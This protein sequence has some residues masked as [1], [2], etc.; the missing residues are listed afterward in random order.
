MVIHT[1]FNACNVHDVRDASDVLVIFSIGATSDVRDAN[2]VC[3]VCDVV[4]LTAGKVCDDDC[5][6]EKRLIHSKS[7]G[8][9]LR[10]L[11]NCINQ[12]SLFRIYEG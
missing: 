11:G 10:L 7:Y 1:I 4:S 12:K 8:H 9:V 2:D 5:D 3:D 6:F